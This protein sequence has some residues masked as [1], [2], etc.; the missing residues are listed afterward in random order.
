MRSAPIMMVEFER[1]SALVRMLR[2]LR[3]EGY[4]RV[5]VYTPYPDEEI[6]RLL[7]GRRS[8]VGWVMLAAGVAGGVG[9][10]VLQWFA[11]HDYPLNVGGR[12]LHSWPAF[13]PVTF[14]LTVLSAAIAGV[15]A[16]LWLARLPRL[17]GAVFADS[18]FWRASQ[19]RFFLCVHADDPRFTA[20]GFDRI[21]RES[22]ALSIGEVEG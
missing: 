22:D 17:D 14:E 4:S 12:P 2:R 11:T 7:P 16:L 1:A 6:D 20:A 13:V 19:D 15:V 3:E 10:Y 5:D 8:P 9:A 21:V 18:R